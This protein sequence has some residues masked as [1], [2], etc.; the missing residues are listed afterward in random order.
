MQETTIGPLDEENP[1]VSD[2]FP[3]LEISGRLL[4]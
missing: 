2:Q 1:E 3:D 4:K